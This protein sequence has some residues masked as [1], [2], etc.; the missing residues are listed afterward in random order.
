MTVFDVKIDM[1]RKARICARGDQTEVPSSITYTSV[2]TRDIIR[3]GF[4]IAALNRLK[5][6]SADVA[7]AYLNARCAEKVY[8]VL[9]DE[10][11]GQVG[12][13]SLKKHYMVSNLRVLPGD[14]F[15]LENSGRR[16][17]LY[18]VEVIWMSGDEHQFGRMEAGIMSISSFIQMMLLQFQKIHKQL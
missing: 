16:W 7:G 11:G 5:V 9:G 18:N 14:P 12:E 2:V 10:F 17:I 8:T 1:T 13:L 15:V 4:L 3:L 6:W